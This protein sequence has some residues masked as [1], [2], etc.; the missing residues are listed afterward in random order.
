MKMIMRL[1]ERMKLIM[2]LPSVQVVVTNT[3]EMLHGSVVLFARGGAIANVLRW[4]KIKPM[5]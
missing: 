5:P 1:R 3:M 2:V 4:W